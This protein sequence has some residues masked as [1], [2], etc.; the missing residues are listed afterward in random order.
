MLLSLQTLKI[1]VNSNG[2]IEATGD[3][4]YVNGVQVTVAAGQG[5]KNADGMYLYLNVDY[6]QLY[7]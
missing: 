2:V 6:Y 3:E 4:I 7:P 1:R 5:V